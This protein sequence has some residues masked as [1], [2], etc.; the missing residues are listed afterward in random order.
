MSTTRTGDEDKK[1][2]T[3]DTPLSEKEEPKEVLSSAFSKTLGTVTFDNSPKTPEG[4][5][6]KLRTVQKVRHDSEHTEVLRDICYV[7]KRHTV[8]AYLPPESDPVPVLVSMLVSSAV[9]GTS[10]KTKGR[11]SVGGG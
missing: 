8:S 5:P 6:E 7:A 1:D 9:I 10:P 3:P 2:E 11:Y 4:V